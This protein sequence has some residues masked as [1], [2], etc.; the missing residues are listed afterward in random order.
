MCSCA[1][2]VYYPG[3]EGTILD[4]N[5]K[6]PIEG[7]YVICIDNCYKLIETINVGGPNSDHLAIHITATDSNG[8]FKLPR[9]FKYTLSSGDLRQILIYKEGY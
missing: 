3:L 1:I 7:A 4:S 8:Y 6:V 5:T 2:P 9:Y